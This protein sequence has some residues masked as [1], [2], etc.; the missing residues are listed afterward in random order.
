MNVK[1]IIN[2]DLP[3][4]DLDK[5]Y[6]NGEEFLNRLADVGIEVAKNGYASAEYTTKMNRPREYDVTKNLVSQSQCEVIASGSDVLFMEYGTGVNAI[7]DES[8]NYG[9]DS[10]SVDHEQEF[11]KYGSWHVRVSPT[12]VVKLKGEPPCLAMHEASKEIKRQVKDIA[13]EVFKW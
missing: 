2:G 9:S 5:I 8:G 7:T 12:E 3:Q 4:V 1:V 6:E 10:W 13:K 11:H